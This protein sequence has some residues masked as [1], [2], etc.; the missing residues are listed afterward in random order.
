MKYTRTLWPTPSTAATNSARSG[1]RGYILQ[2]RYLNSVIHMEETS[3]KQ[4]MLI[5]SYKYQRKS[6]KLSKRSLDYIKVRFLKE[7]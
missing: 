3:G 1:S 6:K 5:T 7:P 4:E 2:I